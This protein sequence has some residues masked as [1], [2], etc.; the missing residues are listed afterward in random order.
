[1]FDIILNSYDKYFKY[2]NLLVVLIL[3]LYYNNNLSHDAVMTDYDTKMW[4]YSLELDY[5]DIMSEN[6]NI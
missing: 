3:T 4:H 1:M 6:D 5:K 2:R